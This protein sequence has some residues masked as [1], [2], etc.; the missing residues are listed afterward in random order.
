MG[1]LLFSYCS[2]T[3]IEAD[4]QGKKK[5]IPPSEQR[6]GDADKGFEYLL[7]GNY[8]S[9][10]IPYL[11]YQSLNPKI[12]QPLVS[13]NPENKNIPPQFTLVTNQDGVKM[14]APNCLT[15]HSEYINGEFVVGLGNTS[16]DYTNDLTAPNTLLNM[17]VSSVYGKDSKEWKAFE[18]FM[19]SSKA[20]G[21]QMKTEVKG[22][23]PA[24]KL[25]AVLVAH[26]DPKTLE[27]H[28]DAQLEI[29]E[30]VIPTDVPPWWLLK[31][32][33]AMFYT[34]IGRGDFS[35]FLMASSLLTMHGIDEAKEIDEKFPDV[36]SWINT[37]E[38]PK[39]P[40]TVDLNKAQSGE[41]IFN[42]NCSGCHGTYGKNESYPNYL[43]AL[44]VVKTDPELSNAYTLDDPIYKPFIE[45]YSKSWFS[46]EP[47]AG[48]LIIEE[49]YVAPPLDGIWASA[50]YL[51][52]GSVPTIE[53]LLNSPQRPTY[54]KRSY[55]SK[56]YNF[57]KLGWHY[58]TL[59]AK[60]DKGTYDTTIRGYG[61]QG[62]YFGDKLSSSERS[63]VIEYLKTL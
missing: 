16:F 5:F 6:T 26:R 21:G 1:I 19:Q 4:M 11:L 61:N 13:R 53:D 35:K 30:A 36:F 63:A 57:E 31:K 3:R 24:D 15:C 49:G 54:W 48:Q 56:D 29:P 28:K 52:N 51:H 39:Y 27:W 20:L 23:N 34:A 14:V 58:E 25:T 40:E 62:H 12:D 18:P 41:V 38:P 43:V 59:E 37:L 32:K 46:Q 10:G 42:K 50:P 33:H 22:I 8:V 45:W 7:N 17:A 47:H 60:N 2:S 44:D 9:S 55:D